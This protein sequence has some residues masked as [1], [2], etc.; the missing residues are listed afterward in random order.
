MST[1]LTKRTK[2][3]LALT[4]LI[5]AYILATNDDA[6][7]NGVVAAAAPSQT[8]TTNVHSE[9]KSQ[10]TKTVSTIVAPVA[11]TVER[12]NE[13]QLFAARTWHKAPPPPRAVAP[14]PPPP[15]TAPP[16]PYVALGSYLKQGSTRVFFLSRG[17]KVYDVKV[18]DE[19]EGIYSVDDF[20]N[21]Q[22]LLT[23][24]PLQIKQVLVVGSG[25]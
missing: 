14:P 22:L 5:I 23:Y 17:D 15:P 3:L 24:K 20:V 7:D 4:A 6:T 2:W 19:L 16:M 13:A 18:G 21:G 25:S 8:K 10:Y 9:T 12:G 11:R 1:M